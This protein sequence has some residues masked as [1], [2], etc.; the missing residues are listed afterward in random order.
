MSAGY[1]QS[2]ITISQEG[3]IYQIEYANKAV[4]EGKTVA[5]LVCEDGVILV[6]EKEKTSKTLVPN[7]NPTIY[8]ITKNIGI[9]ICGYLPDGRNIVARAQLESKSY[10]ENYG[11]EISGKILSDRLAS[12]IQMHTIYWFYRPFG[13]VAFVASYEKK[14]GPH[15]YMIENNGNCYEYYSCSN[16]KGRQYVKND[17]EKNDYAIRKKK[18]SEAFKDLLKILIKSY[19]G[20]RE[21]EYDISV[22]SRDTQ[23][24]HIILDKRQLSELVEKTKKEV[25]EERKNEVDI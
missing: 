19:E 12:Y 6:S 11:I 17:V 9:G 5:G 8:N 25:E 24:R 15:L 21:T 10:L 13:A 3:K 20:E 4:E 7:T 23:G 2:C 1:D 14:D 22:I 16:G 18:S